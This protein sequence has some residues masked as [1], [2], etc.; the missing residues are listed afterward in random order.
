M[1]PRKLYMDI[2]GVLVIWDKQYNCIELARGFGRLLIQ[3]TEW[4]TREQVLHSYELVARYV[5]PQF[6]G[7]LTSLQNSQAWYSESKDELI[8]MVAKSIE[9]AKADYAA[10]KISS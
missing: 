6:Q 10:G 2:D 9:R 5:M 7:S 8:E 4:G 3:A 1:K